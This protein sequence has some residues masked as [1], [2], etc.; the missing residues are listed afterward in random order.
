MGLNPPVRQQRP[1]Q[2]L[3]QTRQVPRAHHAGRGQSR[4]GDRRTLVTRANSTWAQKEGRGWYSS[5]RAPTV[6]P[7]HPGPQP[8]AVAPGRRESVHHSWKTV[9]SPEGRECEEG[10]VQPKVGTRPSSRPRH[11]IVT[12]EQAPSPDAD[13]KKGPSTCAS[14]PDDT[15]AT[16]APQHGRKGGLSRLT[17][18]VP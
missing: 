8:L 14:G 2:M 6:S 18:P 17:T 15:H 13:D 4:P 12:G 3:G 9:T 11:P 7:E 1:D 16:W 5:G 10:G